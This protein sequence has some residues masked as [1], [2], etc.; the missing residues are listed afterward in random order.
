MCTRILYVDEYNVITG[1]NMDWAGSTFSDLWAFPAGMAR[2]GGDYGDKTFTW[3]STYGS[4]ITSGRVT[5]DVKEGCTCDG[6]NHQGLAVNLQVLEES[7][8]P[9]DD[10]S[11][12]K[13]SLAAWTQYILDQCATVDEAVTL[14]KN[15]EF[16]IVPAKMSTT[17]RS[18]QFHISV[19]DATGDSAIFEYE[20]GELKVYHDKQYLVMTNSP[21]YQQ[22]LE[23]YDKLIEEYNEEI[24]GDIKSFYP[25]KLPGYRISTHRFARASFYLWKV[26]RSDLKNPREA[27]A[28]TFSIIRNAATPLNIKDEEQPA[29]SST[30]WST[31]ID[32]KN[33][34]YYYAD[35]LS[36]NIWWINLKDDILKNNTP[37][38]II[39]P[40]TEED[41]NSGDF[42]HLLGNITSHFKQAEPFTFVV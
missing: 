10:G 12:P 24:G 39:L 26:K 42:N 23:E 21:F 36:P 28:N 29:L 15:I 34:N 27:I 9:T 33:L 17:D 30:I 6:I 11:K 22:Q 37:M 19:S 1:R 18:P 7:K 41:F 38:Q 16:I 4:V 40:H 5:P 13:I 25:E 31:V 8:F 20:K 14:M 32:N 35:T 2:N 3:T